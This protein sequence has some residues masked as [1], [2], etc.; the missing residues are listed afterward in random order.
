MNGDLWGNLSPFGKY[1][2][3]LVFFLRMAVVSCYT[4]CGTAGIKGKTSTGP[5]I[6]CFL[7]CFA[8][9]LGVPS[10]PHR[11]FRERFQHASPWRN[12]RATPRAGDRVSD[13]CRA[14]D[15]QLCAGEPPNVPQDV[16]KSY[17]SVTDFGKKLQ[18][19]ASC[20]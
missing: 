6:P 2:C 20:K 15:P 9:P 18:V 17:V 3:R 10:R 4:L 5:P 16:P 7:G 1:A 11:S 13:A 14:G 8:G 19:V 12:F